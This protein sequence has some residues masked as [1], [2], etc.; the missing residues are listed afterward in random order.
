[1]RRAITFV[2]LVLVVGLLQI[3]GAD[4]AP[5]VKFSPGDK[6]VGIHQPPAVTRRCSTRTSP[7]SW[8]PPSHA[9]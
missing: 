7:A 5:P 9:S 4:A 1:M 8:R 6:G 2:S 3:G